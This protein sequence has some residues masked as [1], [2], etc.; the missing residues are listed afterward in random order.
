[1]MT[2]VQKKKKRKTKE[3]ST[4]FNEEPSEVVLHI[5]LS[6]LQLLLHRPGT[7]DSLQA[8]WPA[9]AENNRRSRDRCSQIAQLHVSAHQH[10]PLVVE[11]E[12]LHQHFL[13]L[14]LW[15]RKDTVQK[16]DG[17][18]DGRA[19]AGTVQPSPQSLRLRSSSTPRHSIASSRLS[20]SSTS[21]WR[22]SG[23]ILWSVWTC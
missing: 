6:V 21:T 8:R 22:L 18:I 3:E 10:V 20:R 15:N 2:F 19:A 11:G 5:R 17:R 16:P 23:Q 12:P 7:T 13:L 1:M 9:W 14:L 4:L